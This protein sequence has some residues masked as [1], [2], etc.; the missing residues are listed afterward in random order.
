MSGQ[1]YDAMSVREYQSNGQTKTAWTKIG[2][3]FENKDGSIGIQLDAFPV[4]GK[5]ILQVPLTREER[6]AKFE[7]NRQQ[8]GG[9]Q[10]GR[11]APQRMQRP[12]SPPPQQ[13]EEDPFND[14]GD[15]HGAEG[16]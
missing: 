11:G 3:A 8:R 12:A 10:R 15:D 7:Q 6:E 1:R 2:A 13:E 14:G 5:I 4:N 16:Y 9:G